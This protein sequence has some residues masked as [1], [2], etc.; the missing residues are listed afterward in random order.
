MYIQ[1]GAVLNTLFTTC[2]VN[3][4]LKYLFI[5]ATILNI[6]MAKILAKKY[7]VNKQV[8]QKMFCRQ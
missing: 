6:Y 1:R 4:A 2:I 8:I 3:L 7:N 5:M